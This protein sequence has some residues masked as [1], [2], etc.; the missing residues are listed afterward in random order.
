M[1]ISDVFELS[2]RAGDMGPLADQFAERNAEAWRTGK[3]VGDIETLKVLLKGQT[4][5]VWDGDEVV[6]SVNADVVPNNYTAID[7]AW[8]KGDRRGE[9]LFS[10]VL[11]FLK[12]REGH[13]RLLLGKI[14]S[15]DTQEVIKGLRAFTKTWVKDGEVEPFSPD[16]L[17]RF[18]SASG[19]TG[20][21]LMLEN[22][23]LSADWPKFFTSAN[24]V[25]EGFDAYID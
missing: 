17:D 21:Q 19:P 20:W 11:W 10:K 24:F 12:T 8:V 7:A 18:Y 9:R 22:V 2:M 25:L 4:Y 3:H 23:V 5:S 1:K 14:H 15:R 16:T 13:D 6:A